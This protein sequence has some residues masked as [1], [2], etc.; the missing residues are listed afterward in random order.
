MLTYTAHVYANPLAHFFY[1]LI[2]ID[3]NITQK[4][5][6]Y[7]EYIRGDRVVQIDVSGTE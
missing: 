3:V 4:C 2:I 5:D 7:A 6:M 1:L